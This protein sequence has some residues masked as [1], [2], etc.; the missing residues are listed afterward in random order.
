[1]T[2][3]DNPHF[4]TVAR[5]GQ[6][7]TSQ[8]F[9]IRVLS[10]RTGVGSSTLRAWERRYGLLKPAR[11]PKGHRLYNEQDVARVQRIVTLLEEGHGLS[12]IA[13]RLNE[14]ESISELPEHATDGR[15]GAGNWTR[16]IEQTITAVHD[17]SAER[18]DAIYNEASSLY[19]VD[20][21]T[22]RLLEPVLS[23]L[24]RDWQ[25]REAGI[26]EEHFYTSWLRNRLGARFHHAIGQASG[27]RIICACLPGTFHEI[28]LMLFAIS[29]LSRGYRVL[30]FGANLPLDQLPLIVQAAAAR[31]VIVSARGTTDESIRDSLPALVDAL[32]VPLFLGGEAGDIDI[33]AFEKAGGILLGER[34]SVALRVLGSHVPAHAGERRNLPM[35]EDN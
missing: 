20:M 25:Q 11:T 26:A 1:M 24:G 8:R 2:P 14:Q 21:V 4:P 33:P 31:A 5:P 6:S 32:P 13:R 29:A 10:D 15:H 30:Y 34:V 3:A 12:N 18:V 27:A 28:G 22:E 23:S 17:F 19:P 9:P 16:L 7:L 35:M